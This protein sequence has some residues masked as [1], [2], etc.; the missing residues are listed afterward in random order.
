MH[1]A[2]SLIEV[3]VLLLV[4]SVTLAAFAPV[5]TKRYNESLK[6]NLDSASGSSAFLVVDNDLDNVIL[7]PKG[8]ALKMLEVVSS[9]VVELTNKG[10]N[11][12]EV[13]FI[14]QGAGGGGGGYR[15]VSD[16]A[17]NSSLTGTIGQTVSST[18]DKTW[19]FRIP[20]GITKAKVTISGGG[21]SG[22]AGSTPPSEEYLLPSARNGNEGDLC[23]KK[24]NIGDIPSLLPAGANMA[25]YRDLSSYPEGQRGGVPTGTT[26]VASVASGA[27]S[28]SASN[29]CWYAKTLPTARSS[30]CTNATGY[31][32]CYRTLCTQDAAIN[33][34]AALEP[35][36]QWRL[37]NDAEI[38]RWRVTE[39]SSSA[40]QAMGVVT[41]NASDFCDYTSSGYGAAQCYG[42]GAACQGSANSYC[43]PNYFWS[44]VSQGYYTLYSGTLDGPYNDSITS[45]FS[46]RCVR[47]TSDCGGMK[48]FAGAGGTSGAAL[49]DIEFSSL[50]YGDRLLFT[51]GKAGSNSA[52]GDTTVEHQR[53][54]GLLW[55]K[56]S[57]SAKYTAKG[58]SVGG[59]ASTSGHG[60]KS[61]VSANCL[62]DGSTYST[63]CT[64]G[65]AGND[66]STNTSNSGGSSY[67][68]VGG[69][70][71]NSTSPNGVSS[72]NFGAAGSGG[73]GNVSGGT[74]GAGYAR[75]VYELASVG[76][77]GGAGGYLEKDYSV[78]TNGEEIKVL[79]P[80]N[81]KIR[82]TLGKG[83][84]G[85]ID[86]T[87]ISGM[88][89]KIEKINGS[90]TVETV[91]L[92]ASG[93]LGGTF[94]PI[95]SSIGEVLEA[96]LAKGGE[97]GRVY[98][99]V[100][101]ILTEI[102]VSDVSSEF[103]TENI[104][105]KISGK[106]ADF[107]KGGDGGLST[108][109]NRKPASGGCS[110]VN[111][112]ASFSDCKND[113]KNPTSSLT[114]L[115]DAS[116]KLYKGGGGGAGSGCDDSSCTK[117]SNGAD[118]FVFIK[119]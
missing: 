119:W 70:S 54:N 38:K 19:D 88:D 27:G 44:S 58:G 92:K 62:S 48:L 109:D 32:G 56:V 51:V 116:K 26:I 74:G 90:G 77:G 4:V 49:V 81:S 94:T 72:A 1:T 68:G 50:A 16:I 100:S 96:N 118:G 73:Y 105:K 21:G 30:Y 31:S 117:G 113:L 107:I 5:I 17:T 89:T 52:G 95:N 12:L 104:V 64:L 110:S 40:Y 29:T 55:L 79:V 86:N 60:V 99:D 47:S 91:L 43:Y 14:L 37:P 11:P 20:R 75:V 83:G 7:Y 24:Y 84:E 97:G 111:S 9:N 57:G 78:S 67:Y 106:D 53:W 13:K 61:T 59:S 36:G 101:G 87:G 25:S 22:G 69:A 66:W 71:S 42:L 82:I 23:I 8:D 115:Y 114:P 45:A 15:K 41:S 98:K 6:V 2:I 108:A 85:S 35:A 34:C 46:A 80:A 93:G 65:K 3:L 39:S 112:P 18:V 76:S 102:V 28:G 103:N 33:A 63:G 10:G